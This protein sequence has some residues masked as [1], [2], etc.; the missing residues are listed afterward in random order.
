LQDFADLHQDYTNQLQT[1]SFVLEDP[2]YTNAPL[3]FLADVFE[4]VDGPNATPIVEQKRNYYQSLW[5]IV[6]QPI[7]QTRGLRLI[8]LHH[9]IEPGL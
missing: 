7:N 6:L 2:D 8:L 5:N 4:Y 1:R 3:D 9:L